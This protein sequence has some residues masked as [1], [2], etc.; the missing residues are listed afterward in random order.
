M[1]HHFFFLLSRER[2]DCEIAQ[3]IQVKLVIE[4]EQRRRQEEKDEVTPRVTGFGQP[5]ACR[6]LAAVGQ[7]ACGHRRGW[8]RAWPCVDVHDG[9][10]GAGRLLVKDEL[11]S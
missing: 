11:H 10:K 1:H 8:D 4:A 5:F 2:Q 7:R 6:C 9:R 3:E